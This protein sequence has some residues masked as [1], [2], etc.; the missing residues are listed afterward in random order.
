MYADRISLVGS[1]GVV[2]KKYSFV[3]LL[4]ALNITH[5]NIENQKY[6]F[7]NKCRTI[8]SA[9]NPFIEFQKADQ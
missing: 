2:W 9:I 5:Y 7:K 8:K 6:I 4:N 3:G 1:I